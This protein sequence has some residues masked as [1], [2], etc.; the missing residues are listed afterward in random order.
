M[1]QKLKFG[2]HNCTDSEV[3][4]EA[5]QIAHSSTDPQEQEVEVDN[6]L[7]N[8]LEAVEQHRT[9]NTLLVLEEVELVLEAEEVED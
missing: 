4:L 7:D 1:Q 3:D 2:L 9:G 6:F 5:N 8:L